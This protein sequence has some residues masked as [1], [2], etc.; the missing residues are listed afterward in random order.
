VFNKVSERR[1]KLFLHAVQ[2]FPVIPQR[3][4]R[5]CRKIEAGHKNLSHEP[6]I[7]LNVLR[8]SDGLENFD[9]AIDGTLKLLLRAL[10]R[11]VWGKRQK[12]HRYD[13]PAI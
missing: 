2:I 12:E 7:F 9:D 5:H 6:F 3:L 11:S 10:G 1:Y 8:A 4:L 13:Q